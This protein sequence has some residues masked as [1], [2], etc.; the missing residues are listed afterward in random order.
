MSDKELENF[1]FKF[2]QLRKA[3]YTAHLDIDAYAGRS[4]IGLRVMLDPVQ[5]QNQSKP[6]KHR[7]PSYFRRQEKRKLTQSSA[8]PSHN[9]KK[10]LKKYQK[11][12]QLQIMYQKQLQIQLL[13]LKKHL[14]WIISNKQIMMLV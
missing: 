11:Q 2:W 9:K 8:A 3:G 10:I 13:T 14:L 5:Q 1:I 12:L 6:G 4:W 7:S